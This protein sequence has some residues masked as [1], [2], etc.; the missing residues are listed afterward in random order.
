MGLVLLPFRLKLKLLAAVWLPERR[1][2]AP[3]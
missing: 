3:V 1:V 2:A